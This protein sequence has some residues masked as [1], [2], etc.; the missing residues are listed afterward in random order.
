M[1]KFLKL[2]LNITPFSPNYQLASLGHAL[3]ALSIVPLC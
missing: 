2:G 3:Y 1:Q